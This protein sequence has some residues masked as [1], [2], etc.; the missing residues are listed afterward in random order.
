MKPNPMI[1]DVTCPKC[2]SNTVRNFGWVWKLVAAYFLGMAVVLLRIPAPVPAAGPVWSYPTIAGVVMN[3]YLAGFFAYLSMTIAPQ[4]R[5][6]TC[7]H[8]WR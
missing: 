6:T 7:K 5:C 3:L 1:T 4:R 8:T 2:G